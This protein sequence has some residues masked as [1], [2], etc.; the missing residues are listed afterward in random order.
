MGYES[1]DMIVR[2]IFYVAMC[3]IPIMLCFWITNKVL[4]D[5]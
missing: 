4:F 3:P 2:V 5:I 1:I